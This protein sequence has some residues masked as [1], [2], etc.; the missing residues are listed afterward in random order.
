MDKV[1]LSCIDPAEGPVCN[2]CDRRT[3][4]ASLRPLAVSDASLRTTTTEG[5]DDMARTRVDWRRPNIYSPQPLWEEAAALRATGL[6]WQAIAD[7][8]QA[9]YGIK[10]N[11]G[12]VQHAVRKAQEDEAGDG[13][14]ADLSPRPAAPGTPLAD[15][16]RSHVPGEGG[17]ADGGGGRLEAC[18]TERREDGDGKGGGVEDVYIDFVADDPFDD[19]NAPIRPADGYPRRMDRL[20]YLEI[21]EPTCRVSV[22][23]PGVSIRLTADSVHE[24]VDRAGQAEKLIGGV[25]P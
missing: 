2:D 8:F 4:D 15:R 21:T 23:L 16:K 13:D 18:P 1:E 17:D 20:G 7:D 12:T 11:Q 9:H 3:A 25:M 24:L 19:P 10:V 5:S 22:D 6:T 14:G